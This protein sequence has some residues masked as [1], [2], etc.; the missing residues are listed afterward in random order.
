MATNPL[1]QAP[2]GDYVP[3]VA[4]MTVEQFEQFPMEEG[5]IY[6]LH[7]GRLVSMPGPGRIHGQ[8][9]TKLTLILSQYLTVHQLGTLTGTSCYNLPLPGNRE[10]L[11]C[12][13]LSY[14]LPLREAG[15]VMR[16]S[17]PILAPD[18]VIE[19]SSPRDT[20]PKV[21]QKAAIYLLAGVRLLWVVWPNTQTIDVWLPTAH[22]RPSVTLQTTDT[23]D[24][25]QVISG[26]QH[27]V[28]DVFA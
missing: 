7:E 24:G 27:P 25:L 26:F 4:R 11:L 9:Q 16:G 22:S 18:L 5:W 10:E 14:V 3:R 1:S 8:I 13:D 12:P 15:I 28:S 2:W 6:E 19:I 21:A 17:Y 23:L 20:R